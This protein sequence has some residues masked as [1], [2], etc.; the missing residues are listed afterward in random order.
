MHYLVALAVFSSFG[1]TVFIFLYMQTTRNI[2]EQRGAERYEQYRLFE[3]KTDIGER[4]SLP[5]ENRLRLE[6]VDGMVYGRDI[7]GSRRRMVD[8]SSEAYEQSVSDPGFSGANAVER[9]RRRHEYDEAVAVEHLEPGEVMI[10]FSPIPDDALE[11]KLS[12]QGYR[13]DLARTF[14][15]LYRRDTEAVD[16]VTLSLEQSNKQ[17]LRSAAEKVGLQLP[18]SM[19]SEAVLAS[20][21]VTRLE[22]SDFEELA[23]IIRAQYDLSLYEQTGSIFFAGNR[24]AGRQDSMR[25]INDNHDI[26]DEH[27]AFLRAIEIHLHGSAREQELEQLRQRTAAALD[28]RL[29]GGTV[30]SIGDVSVSDRVGTGNYGGECATG[31]ASSIQEQMGL[32]QGKHT[33]NC[34]LCGTQGVTATVEGETITCSDCRGS[35]NIC[36]GTVTH[37]KTKR[38]PPAILP[39]E[40]PNR[41]VKKPP[42]KEV[43]LS[44][45]YGEKV[46]IKKIKKIGGEDRVAVNS[47][48]E[49]L[50]P[51]V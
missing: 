50:G 13:T 34:P 39:S 4:L 46:T 3:E 8:W 28:E 31:A 14:C 49:I 15:R 1:S 43:L 6:V 20:R 33:T 27:M 10:V 11:G 2:I 12:I 47:R 7:T 26:I 19:Q 36:T 18:P 45:K 30:V 42:A 25:F 9:V 44:Q 16:A 37:S 24:L 23:D 21:H 35:V 38:Q 48:G 40:L 41:S 32:A 29:H 5:I 22:D 51:A 17:A